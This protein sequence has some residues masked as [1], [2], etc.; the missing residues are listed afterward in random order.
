[1]P[2][3][4]K[5]LRVRRDGARRGARAQAAELEPRAAALHQSLFDNEE[6]KRG[7]QG[8]DSKEKFADQNNNLSNYDQEKSCENDAGNKNA[9]PIRSGTNRSKLPNDAQVRENMEIF[10]R[11]FGESHYFV[12]A[13]LEGLSSKNDDQEGAGPSF[14]GGANR[15]SSSAQ[16]G[17]I[18]ECVHEKNF[19][20]DQSVVAHF[21]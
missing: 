15:A 2:L 6:A 8:F 19:L 11:A 17:K 1:M 21:L 9:L 13:G 18:S 5:Q 14:G 10:R 20:F 4:G 12:R 16:R 3:L 7:W